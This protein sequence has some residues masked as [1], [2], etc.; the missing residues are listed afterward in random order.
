M[1]HN[2][3]PRLLSSD[4]IS[5]SGLLSSSRSPI[6]PP[7]SRE[8]PRPASRRHGRA[9]AAAA[10]TVGGEEILGGGHRDGE[11]QLY[12][13][14]V[15]EL[16]AA[17][18]QLEAADIRGER[19]AAALEVSE[20]ERARLEAQRLGLTA[21]LAAGDLG[22]E[23]AS[24]ELGASVEA[25]EPRGELSEAERTAHPPM[26]VAAAELMV[27][28]AARHET[29][30]R[31]S[32]S[33]RSTRHQSEHSAASPPWCPAGG[34]AGARTGGD[35]DDGAGASAGANAGSGPSRDAPSVGCTASR[36]SSFSPARRRRLRER[37]KQQQQ[38]QHQQHHQQQ[39]QQHQQHQHQQHQ[40][41]RVAAGAE[42][43]RT[44]R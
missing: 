15:A 39:Q 11:Q 42:P 7:P 25:E 23:R 6:G 22:S 30:A 13:E 3:P 28:T 33:S 35:A 1:S 14:A 9:G 38:Q 36:T 4:V 19:L 44:R 18:R 21:I 8:A 31:G 26:R 43:C 5:R 2:T 34:G 17:A 12:E 37:R 24:E 16:A 40:R 32:V 20:T 10:V 29:H 27:G 41:R